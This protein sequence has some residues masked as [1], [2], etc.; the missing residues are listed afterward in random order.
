[1]QGHENKIMV[2][3][4]GVGQEFNTSCRLRGPS[5]LLEKYGV[6][7]YLLYVGALTEH[8]NI[9]GVLKAYAQLCRQYPKI[10]PLVVAG[11]V[12]PNLADP[13]R[14]A[15]IQGIEKKVHFLG[16]VL[17]EELPALY[18]GAELFVF[19][20]LHEGFGIPILEAMACGT[21][22]ITSAV[23]G[24][25]EPAGDAALLVDPT[26]P[27]LIQDSMARIL[28]DPV[29]RRSISERGIRRAKEFSWKKMAG[30]VLEVYRE[31][32]EEN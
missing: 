6:K 19:P 14:F 31:V 18:R 1:M 16:Y 29:L 10:P 3:Y 27:G 20:S 30:R 4:N 11:K 21:P 17:D 15:V 13:I 22:V 32:Y 9:F 26:R 12:N 8:K 25:P 7:K 28:F 24:M 5:P 2:V 23:A